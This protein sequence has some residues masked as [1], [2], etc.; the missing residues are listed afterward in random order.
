MN[1]QK[2]YVTYQTFTDIDSLD[3]FSHFLKE[4]EID[5]DIEDMSP[6]FDPSFSFSELNKEFRIKLMKNDFEKVDDLLIK[7]YSDQ[8]ELVEKDYYLFNFTDEE[9][10]EIVTKPDEWNKFDY[11]LAQKILKERDK[12]INPEVIKIINKQRI[13]DLAQPEESQKVW[14][15]CGFA[16]S[17]LGGLL[18]IF[19]GWFLFS[20]KKTLP[21]GDKVYAYSVKD[22]NQGKLIFI[23][24]IFSFSLCTIL[25]IFSLL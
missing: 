5:F 16:C 13:K 19:I 22:R 4:H 20:H 11:L 8:L 1:T 3:D 18:G 6:S 7:Y 25:R 24:G 21:D 12:E 9:L 23:L 17:I 15:I 2:S 10:V 14:I